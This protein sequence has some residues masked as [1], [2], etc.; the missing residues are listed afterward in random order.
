M[1]APCDAFIR[2]GISEKVGICVSSVSFVTAYVVKDDDLAA[3]LIS[4][5]PAYFLMSF[6][7]SHYIDKLCRTQVGLRRYGGRHTIWR[8]VLRCLLC[9]WPD[10]WQGSKRTADA[11]AHDGRGGTTVGATFTVIFI[12][13][14]GK[15][16]SSLTIN[17][18]LTQEKPRCC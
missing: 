7:R 11:V 3:M 10:V 14:E 13:M 8:V 1:Q 18:S 5:V 4:L 6:I 17:L 9:E 16:C 15:S 12:L 2:S